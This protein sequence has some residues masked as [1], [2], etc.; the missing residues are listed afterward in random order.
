MTTP[1]LINHLWQS[2]CFALFTALLALALRKNS[3]KVRYWVWL[4]ASL[5]FLI[6]FALLVSLGSV[7]PRPDP[8]PV[9]IAAPVLPNAF[10]QVAEPFSQTVR[11]TVP[12]RTPL[13][14]VPAA[15]AVV[16][17]LGFLAVTLARCRSWLGVRTALRAG[18][19]VELPIPVPAV[20]TPAAQEPGIVGFLRPVLVLPAQLLEHLNARQLG[21][22]LTHE[23]CHVRRRD[24]FFAAVH[25]VV[26]A[27]FW[28]HPLVWW[29]GSR[30]V[31][32]REL[33]CDEEVLRLGCEPADYVEGILKVCRFYLESPLP[34]ISGVTGADVKKRLRAILA[35]SIASELSG[36][37]KMTLA[38]IG[39]AALAAPFLIGVLNAP[40]IRAQDARAAAPKFEVVSIKPCE[41]PPQRPGD[42]YPSRGN[43][44]PGRLSTGCVPLLDEHGLGLIRGAYASSPFTPINGGPPWIHSAFYEINARAEG[45]PSVRMMK[46]PMMQVLLEEHFHLKIHHQTIEGPV[47]FLSVARGGPKLRSFT[48]GSC[49][50]YSYEKP[51][52]LPAGQE[53]CKSN[54][55]SLS[56]ASVELQGGTLDEFSKLL[57]P[58]LDRPVIDKTGIA[59]RFDLRVE[60]SREGTKLAA[61]PLLSGDG[62]TRA[63]DP[64]GFPSIFT[65]LQG[66]LGLRLEPAKGPVE[67]F[68]IEHMERPTGN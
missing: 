54:I 45:S 18:T 62:P 39:L 33:A 65:A 4:S 8:Q 49:T 44:S 28:F 24:N 30:M 12:A 19:P 7:V 26:E 68:V 51:T 16:W 43:S 22:I 46:G 36:A 48:E 56:P 20:I 53:Y 1:F 17:A 14:W 57:R 15:I 52:P 9:S 35:G 66:Q 60:F 58:V 2:S 23:L 6:P 42:M 50:P 25:M 34:C 38:A 41:L 3:P 11:A 27:I 31:E 29:I 5:K 61:E 13:D 64:T 55:S 47:Y 21:A 67:T 32:E 37:K 40:A 10:I 59:G 63:S